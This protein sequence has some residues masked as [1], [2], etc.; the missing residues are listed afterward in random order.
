ME[1]KKTT[2]V[3]CLTFLMFLS[4][5]NTQYKQIGDTNFYLMPGLSGNGSFVYYRE[6]SSPGFMSI[7]HE[8]IVNDIYWNKQY[9]IAKCCQPD[10]DAIKYW[11]VMNNIDEYNWEKIE[12]RQYLKKKDYENALDSIGLSEKEMEHT[13]GSIPWGIHW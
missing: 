11:Y 6:D 7:K 3:A 12:I 5:D 1:I 9:I 13:D 8:G 4:C 10:N 2:I